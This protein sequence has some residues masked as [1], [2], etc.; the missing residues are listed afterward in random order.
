MPDPTTI[1]V[2]RE[3][4]EHVVWLAQVT[5]DRTEADHAALVYIAH[6]LGILHTGATDGW[7]DNSDNRRGVTDAA[8]RRVAQLASQHAA[9]T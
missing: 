1:T 8:R 9:T 6:A 4:L 3:A 7:K 5:E 2:N